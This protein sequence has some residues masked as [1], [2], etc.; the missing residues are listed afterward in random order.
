MQEWVPLI[1]GR[2]ELVEVAFASVA[3]AW[4]TFLGTKSNF[5][6]F[7]CQTCGES[8]TDCPGIFYQGHL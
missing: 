3:I 6:S 5:I 2:L 1:E 4:S 8:M 7:K